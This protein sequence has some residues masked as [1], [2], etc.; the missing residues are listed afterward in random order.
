MKYIKCKLS[1]RKR[2]DCNENIDL[3]NYSRPD[4]AKLI[5]KKIDIQ[6]RK[7]ISFKYFERFN[8]KAVS[9]ILLVAIKIGKV[10][11]DSRV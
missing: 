10:H 7:Y 1:S 3:I 9:E 2:L 11:K 4:T 8:L 6:L 5:S